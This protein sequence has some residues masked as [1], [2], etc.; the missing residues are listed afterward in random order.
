MWIISC[1]FLCS[2]SKLPSNQVWRRT[3]DATCHPTSVRTSDGHGKVGGIFMVLE[4]ITQDLRE[5]ESDRVCVCVCVCAC[6]CGRGGGPDGGKSNPP[7]ALHTSAFTSQMF[8]QTLSVG[9]GPRRV[10]SQYG[11]NW[12]VSG[13]RACACACVCVDYNMWACCVRTWRLWGCFC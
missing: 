7:R 9:C 2:C 13:V 12:L 8:P 3:A 5:R 1:V 11:F 4:K 10:E 6:V